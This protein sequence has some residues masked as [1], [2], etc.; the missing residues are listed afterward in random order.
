MGKLVFGNKE[1][2]FLWSCAQQCWSLCGGARSLLDHRRYW[3]RGQSFPRI[4]GRGGLWSR[5]RSNLFQLFNIL[6]NCTLQQTKRKAS[7]IP[8]QQ[9]PSQG[10]LQVQHPF[11]WE[12]KNEIYQSK[13]H[14]HTYKTPVTRNNLQHCQ[15][16]SELH[17]ENTWV[18]K[19][20]Q[21]KKTQ[22][23]PPPPLLRGGSRLPDPHW[24]YSPP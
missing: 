6:A 14:K 4:F 23:S 20:R 16:I 1:R 18:K 5:R 13:C 7:F 8:V 10:H 12:K 19:S 2:T 21:K 9:L 24:Q 17:G 15:I 3:Q 22:Q 11:L